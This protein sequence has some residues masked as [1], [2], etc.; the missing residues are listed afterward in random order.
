MKRLGPDVRLEM[1]ADA[2]VLR[3]L[4]QP[5]AE[6]LPALRLHP[7]VA[8]VL[9]HLDQGW[10]TGDLAGHLEQRLH[11]E[12]AVIDEIVGDVELCFRGHFANDNGACCVDLGDLDAILDD[13]DRTL[14][15]PFT[16]RQIVFP[17]D[18]AL[19]PVTLEWVVTRYCNRACI[20]CYQGAILGRP[21]D[22]TLSRERIL[23]ILG[24]A[25]RLGAYNFFVTGGEPLLRDDIYDVLVRALDLGMQPEIISKQFV[26]DS[27]AARLAAAG[28][29]EICLSV[30][31]LDEDAAARLTGVPGYATQIART[32][33]RLT[34]RGIRV[35]AKMVLTSLNLQTLEETVGGLERRGVE[36]LAI[37]TY[38]TN[39]QRNDDALMPSP[40]QLRAVR[41]FVDEHNGRPEREMSIGFDFDDSPRAVEAQAEEFEKDCFACHV[42]TTALLFLPDGR[43]TRCDKQLPGGDFILGDLRFQSVYEVWNSPEMLCS[44]Q[45]DRELFEGTLCYEC[46][47]F[48]T[49]NERAR[50]YYDAYLTSGTLYGPDGSC[51]YYRSTAPRR[52]C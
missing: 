40:D 25:R 21:A 6:R 35:L 11:C 32:I 18:R 7:L 27:D 44:L 1:G 41:R 8:A 15:R 49:C 26:K 36:R 33:E 45:P 39:L 34:S 47:Y 14:E 24:E 16:A 2:P 30:D 10:T 51:P 22:S 31:S 50:C 20:Y 37:D 29:E 5:G 23:D 52:V 43:V 28:L 3:Y 48:E 4:P 38:A 9:G 42:G 46:A 17:A 12:R 13:L 19:F